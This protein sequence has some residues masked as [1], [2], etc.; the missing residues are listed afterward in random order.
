MEVFLGLTTFFF[1]IC[2]LG[3]ALLFFYLLGSPPS[4]L[5]NLEFGEETTYKALL[6][7]FVISLTGFLIPLS[8]LLDNPYFGIFN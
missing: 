1:F 5:R 8:Y 4:E 3:I 7:F 6:F 2:M